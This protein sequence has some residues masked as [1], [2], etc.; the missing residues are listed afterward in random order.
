MFY[1][2]MALFVKT[3]LIYTMIR[4]WS[5]YR[6]KVLALYAFLIFLICY[7]TIILFVKI[8]TCNPIRLYW[9]V[10]RHDGT[11]MNLSAV[12]IADSVISVVTDLA[13]LAFPVALTWSLHVRLS[14]KL[15]V[16]AILGAG[17]IAIAFSIYR[18]VLVI[19][20]EDTTDQLELLMRV[21]LSE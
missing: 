15:H 17:G 20:A 11:C 8:F 9:Q 7:Y 21:L 16:I 3:S 2:P 18:L 4:L 10:N 1:V 13:I 5:P 14:K 19:S 12:I 6:A